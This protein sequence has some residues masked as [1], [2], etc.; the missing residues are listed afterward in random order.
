MK[1]NTIVIFEPEG[2]RVGAAQGA[3][4]I[5]IANEVGVGIRSECGGKGTCGKC[6]III[7]DQRALNQLTETEKTFFSPQ[8][9]RSGYR[10]ACNSM[11]SSPSDSIIIMIPEES[12]TSLRK[13]QVLG[14]ERSVPLNPL[15]AKYKIKL[16][17]P[18][19]QDHM[20]DFERLLACL[21]E[22]NGFERLEVDTSLLMTLPSILRDSNWNVTISIWNKRSIIA[23]EPGDTLDKLFGLAIDIGTSKIVSRLIDLRSGRDISTAPVENPQLIHGEDLISRIAFSKDDNENLGILQKLC[24]KGVNDTINKLCTESGI[25]PTNIY[26]A[27]V[28]GNTA[29]HHIFLGI[30]PKYLAFSPFIPAIKKSIN[31]KAN[32]LNININPEGNVHVLP[33]IAGFVGADAIGDILASGIYESEKIT[34]LVDIGTNTEV[35]LRTENE[36]L[37]CS[38]AS[39]PAFEGA[40]IEYGMKAVSGAIE[41][42]HIVKEPIEVK[43]TTINNSKPVG[44]CGSGVVDAIAQMFKCGIINK[45][46]RFNSEIKTPRLK[47]IN[48]KSVFVLVWKDETKINRDIYISEKDVNEILLAKAAIFAGCS[49]LMKKRKIERED[50]ESVMIAGAF[51]NH[52]D[53]ENAKLIGLI[54]DVPT[55]KIKF[56]G[57]TALTGAKLSLISK[58]MRRHGEFLSKN[59][60]HLE[61]A[62]V[63]DFSTEFIDALQLPHR[64]LE[65][66]PLVKRYLSRRVV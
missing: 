32:K 57:N 45:F 28:V 40:H 34:L 41:K 20:P 37:S 27:V 31:T 15:V 47:N 33:I 36:L 23:I 21:K 65:R 63:S 3:N 5:H 13:F 24:I 30:E 16:P 2:R 56:I 29:M 62:T 50:I 58:D 46:G 52:L 8:E 22:E 6:R 43:Y 4:L 48:G 12:R 1:K 51:G 54:P 7:K 9:I 14:L 49:L 26:E 42:V 60:E 55:N 17:K 64:H 66:F 18:S 10:L 59:V 53:G 44:L 39:G 38:C 11:I 19:L 35:V 25:D 61:L